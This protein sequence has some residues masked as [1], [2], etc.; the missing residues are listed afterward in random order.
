ML[1]ITSLSTREKLH[2]YESPSP[3][4]MLN[5]QHL[6]PSG[7]TL[8]WKRSNSL[9][10]VNM[11]KTHQEQTTNWPYFHAP[12]NPIIYTSIPL[13]HTPHSESSSHCPEEAWVGWFWQWAPPTQT[14][15]W[16]DRITSDGPDKRAGARMPPVGNDAI[17]YLTVV[18]LGEHRVPH[19]RH[20]HGSSIV[21]PAGPAAGTDRANR[22]PG[23]FPT[24]VPHLRSACRCRP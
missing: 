14:L 2:S 7:R 18:T 24:S 21:S 22:L 23:R 15:G 16:W 17:A 10:L 8:R 9:S 11:S 13:H 6:V 4:F 1:I 20:P 3:Y 19:Q 5:L 12:I